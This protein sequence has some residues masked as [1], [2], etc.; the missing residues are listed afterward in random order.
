MV[1]KG[2]SSV[3][4]ADIIADMAHKYRPDAI[5]IEAPG[6]GEG[7][8]DILR[9]IKHLKVV[10]FWPGALAADQGHFYRKRDEIWSL[11]RDWIIDGGVLMTIPSFSSS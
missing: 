2:L 8:I 4:L 6:G 11:A 1:F 9:E 10:E 7:I 5:I 3:K